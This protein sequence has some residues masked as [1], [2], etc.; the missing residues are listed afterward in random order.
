MGYKNLV[1]LHI[2]TDNSDDGFDPVSLMGEYAVKKNLVIAAITDHCECNRYKKDGFDKT[3]RQSFD[4]SIREKENFKNDIKLIA[5]M[6]LGQAMQ[7]LPEA[8]DALAARDYDFVIGSL[9]NVAGEEDFWKVDYKTRDAE[10]LLHRYYDE[11]CELLEWGK[12]DTLAH[13]NYPL[14]YIIGVEHI[15]LN[16]AEYE[17]QVDDVLKLVISKNKALEVNTSGLRQPYGKLIPDVDILTRFKELGGKYVTIGSDAHH[18]YDVGAG[19]T[20]GLN[21]IKQAGFDEITYFEN[22]NPIMLKIE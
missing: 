13:I 10:K 2:H 14:R 12:F 16:L 20:E 6:E 1:D 5:G 19:I 18:Y 22:R 15:D 8:E 21:A 3:I 17:K 7:A 11:L 9:H 4:I